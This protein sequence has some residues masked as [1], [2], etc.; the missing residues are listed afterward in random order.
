M[1]KRLLVPVDLEHPA[2]AQ[3]VVRNALA[4]GG[5]AAE[6]IIMTVIPPI[7]GGIVASYLPKNYD[8]RLKEEMEVRLREFMAEH[9]AD[10]T[11]ERFQYFVAHGPVYEEINMAAKHHDV[12]L[13]VV[14]A[15]KPGSHGL[16]PNAAR[17]A[18]YGENNVLIIR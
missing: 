13:V 12:D 14:S 3:K 8:K 11:H 2:S 10:A 9:F 6:Y 1:F 4:L 17:V 15:V 18:R 5:E 16:G 7:G